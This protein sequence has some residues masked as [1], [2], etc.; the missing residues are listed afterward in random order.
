MAV[1]EKRI[2]KRWAAQ[3]KLAEWM[4]SRGHDHVARILL[5]NLV[6]RI[7]KSVPR[8][9]GKEA[10]SLLIWEINQLMEQL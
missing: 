6:K 5:R 7:E 10:G 1:E 9:V 2:I 4:N 8:I 3:V